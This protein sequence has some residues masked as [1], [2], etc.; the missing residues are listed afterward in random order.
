MPYPA[1]PYLDYRYT[2]TGFRKE[3]A[4]HLEEMMMIIEE[5]CRRHGY[6]IHGKEAFFEA[7]VECCYRN[8]EKRPFRKS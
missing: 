5:Q 7:F 8:S 1:H 6:R 4:E 3:Y 2:R